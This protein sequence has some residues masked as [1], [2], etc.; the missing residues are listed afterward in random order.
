MSITQRP[1]SNFNNELYT[2]IKQSEGFRKKV[3]SDH[4]GVPTI[5]IGYALL[6]KINGEW[7]ITPNIDPQLQSAG[8]NIQLILLR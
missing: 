8:I 2:F 1:A 5:G 4:V 6:Q 7:Q 3:Y